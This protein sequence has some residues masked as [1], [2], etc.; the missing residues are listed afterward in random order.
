MKVNASRAKSERAWGAES[1]RALG[2]RIRPG[3]D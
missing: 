1:E 2:V 3:L